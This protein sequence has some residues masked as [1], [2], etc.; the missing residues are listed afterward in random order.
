MQESEKLL[1]LHSYLLLFLSGVPKYGGLLSKISWLCSP[2]RVWSRP[3]PIVSVLLDSIFILS[4]SC[5]VLCLNGLSNPYCGYLALT[6]G[7]GKNKPKFQLAN[8]RFSFSHLSDGIPIL[9]S[10]GTEIITRQVDGL[11]PSIYIWWVHEKILVT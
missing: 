4:P 10:I 7:E 5:G 3:H 6:I 11:P 2:P 9:P 1:T 8:I